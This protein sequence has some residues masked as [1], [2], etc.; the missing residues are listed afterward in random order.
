MNAESVKPV[1]LLLEEIIMDSTTST[2]I[3]SSKN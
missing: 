3:V 2:K 1:Y